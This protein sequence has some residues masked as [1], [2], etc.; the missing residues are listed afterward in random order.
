MLDTLPPLPAS[1]APQFIQTLTTPLASSP[2]TAHLFYPHLQALL[3]YLPPLILPQFNDPGP[4]PTTARP[5]PSGGSPSGSKTPNGTGPAT[6]AGP[7]TPTQGRP[8]AS[9]FT[10]PPP[11]QL[12]K[13]PSP[14]PRGDPEEH[15]HEQATRRAAL[16][17]LVAL[18]EARP[19]MVKRVDGWVAL[20]VRACSEG[21]GEI[22]EGE[23]GGGGG[24]MGRKSD[25]EEE[26]LRMWLDADVGR[27]SILAC[28]DGLM[29]MMVVS[30][31]RTR[32]TTFTRTCMSNR[33]IGSRA[34]WAGRCSS[35]MHSSASCPTFLHPLTAYLV[36]TGTFPRC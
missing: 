2:A 5:F 26:G 24:G 21:M 28:D 7:S 23:E 9:A 35:P 13:S 16:E 11:Q 19:G 29:A 33:L 22:G 1:R 27:V 3:A 17:L 4:T 6:E 18:T 14:Q 36:C 30:P 8:A 32:R 20:G 25:D 15:E 34:L 12:Q 10:F 31:H